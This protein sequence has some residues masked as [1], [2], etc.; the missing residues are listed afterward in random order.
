MTH[1]PEKRQTII[2]LLIKRFTRNQDGVTIVE[3]ALLAPIFFLVIGAILET[4]VIFM[5]SQ[6]LD[7]AVRDSA[8]LIKT[9]QAQDY[10]VTQFK[11]NVCGRLLGLFNC[12]DLRVDVQVLNSFTGNV[13]PPVL[14]PLTGEWLIVDAYN[15]GHATD[16]I[17]VQVFYKWPVILNVP[18]LNQG[19]TADGKRL[20]AG[21]SIFRNEPYGK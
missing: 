18:G 20:M 3:F 7:S 13:K 2:K 8:R 10:S 9:G 17:L 5:S 11:N 6:T 15:A 16:I 19:T 4:A 21:V 1:M 14:D 12:E